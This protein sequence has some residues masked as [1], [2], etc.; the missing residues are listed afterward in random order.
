M[1][2]A[3]RRAKTVGALLDAGVASF[4]QNGYE[5]SSLDSIAWM[6]G[7]SKG[8]VYAH[9]TSKVQIFLAALD[10][11]LAEA[12]ERLTSVAAELA[13]G[14]E[15]AIASRAYFGRGNDAVHVGLMSETWQV[16]VSEE[17]V[18]TRFEDFRRERLALLGQAAVEGGHVPAAAIQ[19]A[20][21]TAKLIDG[22]TLERRLDRA[23]SA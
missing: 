15:P 13:A 14:H 3:E 9:F 23:A 2:Q 7:F 11:T 6:A 10:R 16:A 12:R 1:R 18:R 19:V 17:L 20:D 4:S 21:M 22:W 5:G 8:A